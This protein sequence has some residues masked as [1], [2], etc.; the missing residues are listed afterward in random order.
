MWLLTRIA[1]ISSWSSYS[2]FID[3][4]LS[5][6]NPQCQ[7][8]YIKSPPPCLS[9][10]FPYWALEMVAPGATVLPV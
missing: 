10:P 3:F 5:T 1:G 4:S 2:K 7:V 6:F 8:S 9:A